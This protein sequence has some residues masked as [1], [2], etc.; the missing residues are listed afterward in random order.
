MPARRAVLA[1]VHTLW[2]VNRTNKGLAG[3]ATEGT[4]PTDRNLARLEGGRRAPTVNDR[5]LSAA[6]PYEF[7][8]LAA[9]GL[10]PQEHSLGYAISTVT[11]SFKCEHS[12]LSLVILHVN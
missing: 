6:I 12:A 5:A 7:S 1:A 8:T 10:V 9:N 2:P 4:K 3:S 11:P